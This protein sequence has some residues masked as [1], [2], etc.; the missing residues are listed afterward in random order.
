[1]VDQNLLFKGDSSAEIK[2]QLIT[3]Y[4]RIIATLA[5]M[6]DSELST[7]IGGHEM[8]GEHLLGE[9]IGRYFIGHD[10]LHVN[11]AQVHLN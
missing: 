6:Q 11:Q 8:W 3:S 5:K 10:Q 2:A 7:I 4:E 9:F 1:M